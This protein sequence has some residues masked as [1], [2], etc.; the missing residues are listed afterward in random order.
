MAEAR[1]LDTA[2]EVADL[3]AELFLMAGSHVRW[4]ASA[5]D[6]AAMGDTAKAGLLAA[7]IALRERLTRSAEGR[8]ALRNLGFEQILQEVERDRT[9]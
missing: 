5:L 2:A 4:P 3:A 1:K 8:E 7:A 6:V 9:A